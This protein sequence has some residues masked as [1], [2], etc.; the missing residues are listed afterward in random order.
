MGRRCKESLMRRMSLTEEMWASI[1]FRNRMESYAWPHLLAAAHSVNPD[2]DDFQDDLDVKHPRSGNEIS[3]GQPA[4]PTVSGAIP[5]TGRVWRPKRVELAEP[6]DP[7]PQLP[8]EARE[9]KYPIPSGRRGVVSRPVRRVRVSTPTPPTGG[10]TDMDEDEESTD[11]ELPQR[12][13][14]LPTH[15]ASDQLSCCERLS[16][17]EF[18]TLRKRTITWMKNREE[19]AMRATKI[20]A[21]WRPRLARHFGMKGKR[22]KVWAVTS[23][24]LIRAFDY[25]SDE[26]LKGF[27][28]LPSVITIPDFI[29][30]KPQ[31]RRSISW[32]KAWARFG[33]RATTI[34]GRPIKL[35][36]T[37]VAAVVTGIFA[38][39]AGIINHI[40]TGERKFYDH[41]LLCKHA[42]RTSDEDS[43]VDVCTEQ[44]CEMASG[45]P[46]VDENIADNRLVE[47]LRTWVTLKP[48]N[49]PTFAMLIGRAKAW[50]RKV[51]MSDSCFHRV[52]PVSIALAF[53]HSRHEIRA[54]QELKRTSAINTVKY[55]RDITTMMSKIPTFTDVLRG[56]ASLKDW[57]RGTPMVP[58][59]LEIH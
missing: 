49:A 6:T 43:M 53:Q 41:Q 31:D 56:R 36:A 25:F 3:V 13:I 24:F 8:I 14:A 38:G 28:N 40:P 48:R 37:S 39:I 4:Q 26:T 51:G 7:L 23:A 5:N 1:P 10:D 34:V 35:I 47:H 32:I 17:V 29:V 12:P 42:I 16:R 30:Q 45:D 55:G 21:R 19:D 22:V 33:F 15:G 9:R 54:M 2:L 20:S 58:R 59:G 44:A 11:E 50:Q 27:K 18:E 52:A 46:I 57:W